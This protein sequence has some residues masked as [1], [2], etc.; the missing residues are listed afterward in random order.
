MRII[1]DETI[2]CQTFESSDTRFRLMLTQCTFSKGGHLECQHILCALGT[3]LAQPIN[4]DSLQL[5]L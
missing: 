5:L 1:T 4:E 2:R 3:R